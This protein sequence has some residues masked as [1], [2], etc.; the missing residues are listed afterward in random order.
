MKQLL[1]LGAAAIAVAAVTACSDQDFSDFAQSNSKKSTITAV[2]N[3]ESDSRAQADNDGIFTWSENDEISLFSS[4]GASVAHVLESGQG[5]A[6][7]TFTAKSD[8][9]SVSEDDATYAFYPHHD[10][11][12]LS[13]DNK[14]TVTLPEEYTYSTTSAGVIIPNTNSPMLGKLNSENKYEFNHLAGALCLT[15]RTLPVGAAGVK[16][17]AN[18]RIT[19]TFTA[20]LGDDTPEI[21]SASLTAASD[22]TDAD[23]KSITIKFP[24]L[25]SAQTG[26]RILIPLPTGTYDGFTVSILNSSYEVLDGLTFTS[27]TSNKLARQDLARYK[28]LI[29]SDGKLTV[30][31]SDAKA[32]KTALEGD[33]E[34][35]TL[36]Q[37][38][39]LTGVSI[40]IP[41]DKTKVLDL[42]GHTLTVDATVANRIKVAGGLT[43]KDST[44]DATGVG[45]GKIVDVSDSNSSLFWLGDPDATNHTTSDAEG[46]LTLESGVIKATY[47]AFI[48][49][50]KYVLNL[51]GGKVTSG[52]TGLYAYDNSVINVE[53]QDSKTFEFTSGAI[54]L[55][56]SNNVTINVKGGTLATTGTNSGVVIV[57]NTSSINISGGNIN[58]KLFAL[59]SSGP[60]NINISGTAAITANTYAVKVEETS[61]VGGTLKISG[62]DIIAGGGVE[63]TKNYVAYGVNMKTRSTE[64]NA[65]TGYSFE[66]TGGKISSSGYG[67]ALFGYPSA[68]VSNATV[69]GRALAFSGNGNWYDP[70]V[71]YTF[72]N[73]TFTNPECYAVYLP[74]GVTTTITGTTTIKGVGGIAIQRGILNIGTEGGSND[75]ISI[76]AT[77]TES[78]VIPLSGDGT[79]GLQNAVISAPARYGA[80]TVNIYGGKFTVEHTDYANII[81]LTHNGH[82]DTYSTSD[83]HYDRTISIYGGKFTTDPSKIV[84]K[85]YTFDSDNKETASEY[86]TYE[87][88]V[89]TG[90]TVTTDTDGYYKVQ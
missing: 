51:N 19:G 61:G 49:R 76:T 66:M 83:K 28:T 87:E 80:L 45:E 36:T 68:K 62:G 25:T 69:E 64:A 57:L 79:N 70:E 53:P 46:S 40:T 43:I 31:S 52:S 72:E 22:A 44:A 60:A 33:D 74:N 27:E 23:G 34:T 85:L 42:N 56:A 84:N 13:S 47:Y 3:N 82:I 65:E 81:D 16:F 89:A 90:K 15:F 41:K 24:E 35:V 8:V 73:A 37:D 6:T 14:L 39:D 67:V 21:T 32:L 10:A 2:I 54:T 71:T 5:T 4:E 30:V 17:T 75:D 59:L 63:A 50:D 48:V 11:H 18:T 26:T 77:A 20:T 88:F 9:A 1:T 7:A 86:K 58:G 12:K 55:Y 29:I 78:A 38:V